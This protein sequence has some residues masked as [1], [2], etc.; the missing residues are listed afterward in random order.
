MGNTASLRRPVGA[1][2][3]AGRAITLHPILSAPSGSL[4]SR[5]M[6]A[7]MF[8]DTDT[9]PDDLYRLVCLKRGR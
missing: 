9:P 6:S 7:Y 8:R 4:R 3:A 5:D 2:V 1:A